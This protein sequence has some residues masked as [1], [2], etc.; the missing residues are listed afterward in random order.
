MKIAGFEKT[1]L[2]DWEGRNPCKILMSG[3]DFRCPF[4]NRPDLVCDACGSGIDQKTILEYIEGNRD[5]LDAAV[6]SGGEPLMNPDLYHLLKELKKTGIMISVETNG[7]H[8]DDLD[9]LIGSGLVDRVA[10]NV[11]SPLNNERYSVA[12]GVPVEVGSI[13]RSIDLILRYGIRN[14]FRTVAVP[15]SI[16]I[17]DIGSIAKSIRGADVYVIQQFDPRRT[18]DEKYADIRQHPNQMLMK[19]AETAKKYVKNVKIKGF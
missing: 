19:M 12:A 10:V 14:E 15:G 3:C 4:C 5:F 16:E 7:N 6:I 13:E 9:D 18:L 17:P 8:P 11:I 1:A 2:R